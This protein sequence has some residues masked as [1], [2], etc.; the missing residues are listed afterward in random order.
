MYIVC[1]INGYVLLTL[2]ASL[3]AGF[4]VGVVLLWGFV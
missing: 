4:P 1:I 3:A 2:H